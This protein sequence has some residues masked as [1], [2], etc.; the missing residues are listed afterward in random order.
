MDEGDARALAKRRDRH[1]P[2]QGPAFDHG[3]ARRL[4]EKRLIGFLE[5][6]ACSEAEIGELLAL[7]RIYRACLSGPPADDRL[8]RVL[9]LCSIADP[10]PVA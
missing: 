3:K 8:A 7:A 1:A 9:W 10:G 4:I 2:S 5:D 6:P